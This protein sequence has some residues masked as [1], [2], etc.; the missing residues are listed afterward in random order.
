MKK[1]IL[2]SAKSSF[3]FTVAIFVSFGSAIVALKLMEKIVPTMMVAVMEVV[4]VEVKISADAFWITALILVVWAMDL[5]VRPIVKDMM[6]LFY[7]IGKMEEKEV[8]EDGHATTAT[9]ADA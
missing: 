7:R 3:A 6:E 1:T 5:F 9:K 8:T 2:N 4:P